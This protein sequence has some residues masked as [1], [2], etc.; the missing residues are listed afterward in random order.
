M[1]RRDYAILL[2]LARLGLRA[3]EVA[4]LELEE[5]IGT[6]T[7]EGPGKRRSATDLP[8]PA[9]V[10]AAIAAYL[11]CGRPAEHQSPRVFAGAKPPSAALL[12]QRLSDRSFGMPSQRAGIQAPT[13]GAHQFRH[14]WRPR[15]CVT[16]PR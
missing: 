2:L 3:G 16:A 5:L 12:G 15:C 4:L 10:G 11:R 1:G 9:D 13:K 8:L 14:G 6:R 7:V